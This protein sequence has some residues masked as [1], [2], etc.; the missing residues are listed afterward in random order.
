MNSVTFKHLHSKYPLDLVVS[1]TKMFGVETHRAEVYCQQRLKDRCIPSLPALP[2]IV[3]QRQRQ[4]QR[5]VVI[6][7]RPQ[8]QLKS[9]W[10]RYQIEMPMV[11]DGAGLF[12]SDGHFDEFMNSIKHSIQRQ[13]G[14]RA[15][16]EGYVSGLGVHHQWT[17]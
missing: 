9:L 13:Q 3:P 16:S 4:Q 1:A 7:P 8:S 2:R 11:G 12:E 17:R 5:P 14:R 10:G 6:K 15:K